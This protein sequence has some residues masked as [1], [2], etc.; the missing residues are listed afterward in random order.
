MDLGRRSCRQTGAWTR[1]HVVWEA[2]ARQA[3]ST[4]LSGLQG[5]TCRCN[6]LCAT[7]RRWG[8]ERSD[9]IRFEKELEL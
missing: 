2:G 1:R 7:D 6:A 9:M 8:E 4:H 3:G 5:W